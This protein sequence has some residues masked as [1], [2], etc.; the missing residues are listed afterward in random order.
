MIDSPLD[1]PTGSTPSGNDRPASQ[2]I[3]NQWM[4]TAPLG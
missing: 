1:I 2:W 4:Q 3:E